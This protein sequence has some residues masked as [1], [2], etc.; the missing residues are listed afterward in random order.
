[1]QDSNGILYILNGHFT[2]AV[3]YVPEWVCVVDCTE[4]DASLEVYS[5]LYKKKESL[6][7]RDYH[8]IRYISSR[9]L[10]SILAGM[11]L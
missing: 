4:V 8:V 7:S 1:M 3:N 11:S 10:V 5:N 2:V 6:R 9:S